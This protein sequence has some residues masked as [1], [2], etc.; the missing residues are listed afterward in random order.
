MSTSALSLSKTMFERWDGENMGL[1]LVKTPDQEI[2]N[3]FCFTQAPES[4][5]L[6]GT[7]KIE[8]RGLL[9]VGTLTFDPEESSQ[10]LSHR[11]ASHP[12]SH[13]AWQKQRPEAGTQLPPRPHTALRSPSNSLV[14]LHENGWIT[15]S[16]GQTGEYLQLLLEAVMVSAQGKAGGRESKKMDESKTVVV[17]YHC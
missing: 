3:I 1:I 7:S 2:L 9:E 6:R 17:I 15:S 10:Q 12:F 13:H 4:E 11:F 16:R 14:L 5:Y 8:V